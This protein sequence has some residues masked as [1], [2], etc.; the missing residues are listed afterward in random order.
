[1]PLH[2]QL[3]PLAEG[4]SGPDAVKMSDM[5]PDEARASYLALAGLFGPGENVGAVADRTV[6]GPEG[7]IPV[8]V[9]TPSDVDGPAPV[10]VFYH[11]GGWVI[12]DL[13]SHDRE[14]RAICNRARCIV[15]SVH[16]R[17]APEAPFPAAF[18]DAVAA[19][20]WV[21]ANAAAVGGDPARIAVAGDSAGG[22]LA[23][24][25]SLM[26]RDLGGPAVGFQLLIYPIV[27]CDFDRPSYTEN[28]DGYMLTRDVMMWFWDQYVPDTA[29]RS[30]PYVNV[31]ATEDLRGLPPTHVITAEYDP[32][33]DEGE[34]Y[35]ARLEA[36]GVP[37]T[38][39]RYDGM[40]H[41]FLSFADF[42]DVGKQALTE[43]AAALQ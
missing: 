8:R 15:V 12:G 13:D 31:L 37:V 35:A 43:A 5:T 14:C 2:P 11:G 6:P 1:M 41:G 16:Y 10:V 39:T 22:N 36:A 30:D 40:I 38:H 33:R 23:A 25:V 19:L 42:V 29:R 4:M 27:D 7:E 24:A 28:A 20:D 18:D 9:Y 34:A 26:A 32:L 3:V 17:L 21:G